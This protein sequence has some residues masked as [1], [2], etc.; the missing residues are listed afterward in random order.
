MT[1]R[2][3]H[4]QILSLLA[5][6]YSVAKAAKVLGLEE[7]DIRAALRTA[8]DN[9]RNG[10]HLRQVWA[11]EDWRLSKLLSKLF[12]D[13]MAA[14]G[15]DAWHA[16]VA[17]TRVSSRRAELC[18]ANAPLSSAVTIMQTAAPP[19]LNSTQELRL[20]VDRVLGLDTKPEDILEEWEGRRP[21]LEAKRSKAQAAIERQRNEG[22]QE[23]KA[24]ELA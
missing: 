18:G 21:E 5:K 17:Y 23:P 10:E 6:G 24:N 11:L 7:A 19:Q 13:A 2:D 1:E 3:D 22:K 8:T 15:A 16:S 14:E 20:G 9:F 4:E 12:E